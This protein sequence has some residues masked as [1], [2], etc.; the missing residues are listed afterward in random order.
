M[1]ENG[2]PISCYL[3]DK[4]LGLAP[5]QTMTE[6]AVARV[7][8]EAVQTSYRKGGIAAS[9]DGI[10]KG[11]IKNILHDIKFPPS[12]RIPMVKKEGVVGCSAEGH[13]YHVLSSQMML[14]EK[15]SRIHNQQMYGK[16]AE[17]MRGTLSI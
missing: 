12:F 13:V 5:N 4:I 14:S 2:K 3:I 7:Y 10:S 8:E 16:Y 6:D 1:D 11:T 15:T 17:T 9:P